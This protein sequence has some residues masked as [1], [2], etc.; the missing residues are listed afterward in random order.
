MGNRKKS[1]SNNSPYPSGSDFGEITVPISW[2]IH[3]HSAD[4]LAC[5]FDYS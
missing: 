5:N 3:M 4:A 1:S 2:P